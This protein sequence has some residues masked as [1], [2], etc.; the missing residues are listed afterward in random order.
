LDLLS[1]AEVVPFDRQGTE[2]RMTDRFEGKVVT[3]TGAASGIGE[4]A[5]R[6]FAA[7][8]ARVALIDRNQALLEKVADELSP[9]RTLVQVGDV[10]DPAVVDKMVSEVVVRFG[11]LDVLVNNAGVHEGGEPMDITNDKWREVMA[12]DLD[13][14]FFG[15]RAAL[16]HLMKTK[17]CIINTA[18]V[19]GLGGDWGMIWERGASVSM[20]SVPA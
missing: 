1:Q 14:V 9:D 15:C 17:G 18:S 3:V 7:E 10:S 20:P 11:R 6:R 2:L 16:P 5:A 12:T 4:A 8:G 19:S 13:G